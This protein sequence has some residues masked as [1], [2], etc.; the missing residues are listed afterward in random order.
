[1]DVKFARNIVFVFVVAGLCS[2]ISLQAD[3]VS[4]KNGDRLSGKLVGVRGNALMFETAYAQNP[5]AISLSGIK[6]IEIGRVCRLGITNGDAISGEITGVRP[7]ALVLK[8]AYQARL[9]VQTEQIQNLERLAAE[10]V[11]DIAGASTASGQAAASEGKSEATPLSS[12]ES[13]NPIKERRESLWEGA[14][15]IGGN[16]QTGNTERTSANVEVN[17]RRETEMDGIDLL[18]RYNYAEEDDSLTARDVYGEMTYKYNLS[19]RWYWSLSSSLLS[20]EFRDLDLRSTAALSVGYRW[21]DSE[22]F[23]LTTEAGLTYISRNYETNPDETSLAGR[24][25]LDF[26]GELTETLSVFENITIYPD[27]QGNGHIVHNE[28]GLKSRLSS[29]WHLRLSHVTD[30][31]SDPPG[32]LEDTDTILSLGIGY[33]F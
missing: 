17:A 26:D 31:N 32:S 2:A 28:M 1:M 14:V 22:R 4:L 10:Q 30:Y 15:S 25:S 19:K 3:K 20:D 13:G 16:R 18:F 6:A 9:T 27:F 21:L 5:I 29:A 12:E 33:D 8:T 7:A 24:L 23:S 11:E